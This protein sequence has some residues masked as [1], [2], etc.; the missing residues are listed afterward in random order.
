MKIVLSI[1][2]AFLFSLTLSAQVWSAEYPEA[3]ATAATTGKNVVL[4][5][6]G[7]DWCAPCIRL[8]REIWAAE[9]F[10]ELAGK[11]F[12]F[13]KADF[14]RKKANQLP[15]DVARQNAELAEKYNTMGAFPL[16]VVLTPAGDVL[17]QT[18]YKK[19]TPAAYL[20][21]LQSFVE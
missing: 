15:E 14:P 16:V 9:G 20:S 3:Q 5:F 7:S 10:A 18:G 11:D 8:E 17:G 12:V 1:S 6:A 13:Y 2:L 21:T 4:V 19:V